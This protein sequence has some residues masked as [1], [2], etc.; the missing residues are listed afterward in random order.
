[1]FALN[2]FIFGF[3]E[4]YF[5]INAITASQNSYLRL[6][7]NPCKFELLFLSVELSVGSLASPLQEGRQVP[8]QLR[9]VHQS[10]FDIFGCKIK[11]INHNFINA[12]TGSITIDYWRREYRESTRGFTD[13]GLQGSCQC[14][15]FHCSI[16]LHSDIGWPVQKHTSLLNSNINNDRPGVDVVPHAREQYRKGLAVNVKDIA[17]FHGIDRF[18]NRTDLQIELDDA[19]EKLLADLNIHQRGVIDFEHGLAGVQIF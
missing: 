4:S 18:G 17:Y 3:L 7:L 9:R 8:G 1:M 5:D 2:A 16:R 14:L 10:S 12:H 11:S 15:Y 6:N 19:I 13:V